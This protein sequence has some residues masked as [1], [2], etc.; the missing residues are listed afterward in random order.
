[1]Y[2]TLTTAAQRQKARN[3]EKRASARARELESLASMA[4]NDGQ[5]KMLRAKA[6]MERRKAWDARRILGVENL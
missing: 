5:A 2:A 3:D 6:K 4:L 1:M